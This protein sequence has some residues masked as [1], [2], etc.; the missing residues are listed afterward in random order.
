VKVNGN[1]GTTG[2]ATA[3]CPKGQ[4]PIAGGWNSP[5]SVRELTRQRQ[6]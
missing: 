4:T 6:A 1:G 2:T 3:T 5:G